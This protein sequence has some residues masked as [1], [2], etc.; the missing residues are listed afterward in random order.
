[1]NGVFGFGTLLQA[2][3]ALAHPFLLGFCHQEIIV[4]VL[5]AA[6]VLHKSETSAEKC[7]FFALFRR[8]FVVFQT[9]KRK[10]VKNL[11]ISACLY[12]TVRF[13]IVQAMLPVFHFTS[14]PCTV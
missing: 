4:D 7:I 2:I 8:Y 10:C 14:A 12:H 9:N 1:M 6:K 5:D 3:D 11:H 13:H